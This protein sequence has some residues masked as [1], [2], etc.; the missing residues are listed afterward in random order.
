[1]T[2]VFHYRPLL[3]RLPVKAL[4]VLIKTLNPAVIFFDHGH[5]IV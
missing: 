1:M 4:V 3:C 5:S 2:D